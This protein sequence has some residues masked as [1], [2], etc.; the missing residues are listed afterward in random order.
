MAGS[1][2]TET[3]RVDVIDEQGRVVESVYVGEISGIP[4]RDDTP[5]PASAGA[6][7]GRAS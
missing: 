6:Q 5:P 7:R 2:L 1:E 4:R 3:L